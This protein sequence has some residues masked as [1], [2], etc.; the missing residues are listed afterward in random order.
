MGNNLTTG[1]CTPHFHF[2]KKIPDSIKETYSWQRLV[3]ADGIPREIYKHSKPAIAGQ[4]L[5]MV[6]AVLVNKMLV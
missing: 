6:I 2:I 4:L 3:G 1:T 5:V